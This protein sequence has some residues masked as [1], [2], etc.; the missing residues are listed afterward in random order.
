MFYNEHRTANRAHE[1]G[2]PWEPAPCADP[3]ASPDL[4]LSPRGPQEWKPPKGTDVHLPAT[5]V[6]IT[7]TT[8]P[9]TQRVL[10]K[11]TEEENKPIG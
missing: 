6:S 10:S 11:C 1:G 8:G 5:A 4:T 2:R 7:S 9:G 3:T